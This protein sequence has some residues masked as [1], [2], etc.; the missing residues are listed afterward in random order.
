M[1]TKLW[2]VLYK[3]ERAL[4]RRAL[5]SIESLGIT[6]TDFAILEVLLHKGPLPINTIGRKILLTSGSIT[7]AVDRLEARGLVSRSFDAADRR[8]RLVVLTKDGARA[9]ST[10]FKEHQRHLHQ[11]MEVLSEREQIQLIALLKKLGKG[12]ESNEE[13]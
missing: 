4:E 1:A 3:A 8:I 2:L 5:G 10:S 9:A 12:V 11:A 6:G 13:E 7:T